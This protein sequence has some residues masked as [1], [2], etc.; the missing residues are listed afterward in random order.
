VVAKKKPSF[1]TFTE[2]TRTPHHSHGKTVGTGGLISS[3]TTIIRGSAVDSRQLA[4]C[5]RG[6]RINIYR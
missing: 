3:R 6:K 2:S 1:F 5:R 4:T